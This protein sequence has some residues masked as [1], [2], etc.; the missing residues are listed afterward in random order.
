MIVRRVSFANNGWR[1]PK[2]TPSS[3]WKIPCLAIIDYRAI[4]NSVSTN[5]V[6]RERKET[7]RA[8]FRQKAEQHNP[9]ASI[10]VA[11]A[12][13]RAQFSFDVVFSAM[14]ALRRS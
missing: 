3:N 10:K 4:E 14:V 2:E 6:S 8:N 1:E 11:V 5:H 7:R 12:G 13:E 9:L